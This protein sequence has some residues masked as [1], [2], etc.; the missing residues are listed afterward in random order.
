VAKP[1]KINDK[2]FK[3][4]LQSKYSKSKADLIF[5]YKIEEKSTEV[6]PEINQILDTDNIPSDEE[7]M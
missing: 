3:P 6:E 5:P 2:I 7:D 4:I 1:A